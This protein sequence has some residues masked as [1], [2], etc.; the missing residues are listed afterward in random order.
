MMSADDEYSMKS[1]KIFLYNGQAQRLFW[2]ILDLAKTS[3]LSEIRVEW[4]LRFP[5]TLVMVATRQQTNTSLP[6]PATLGSLRGPHDISVLSGSLHFR[7]KHRIMQGVSPSQARLG[8]GQQGQR[9]KRSRDDSGNNNNGGQM[10]NNNAGQMQN[11]H[12]MNNMNQNMNPNMNNAALMQNRVLA[13]MQGPGIM[14]TNNSMANNRDNR[15]FRGNNM[16]MSSDFMSSDSRYEGDEDD[17]DEDQQTDIKAEELKYFR[18]DV[19]RS[20]ISGSA[21]SLNETISNLGLLG[22]GRSQR[23]RNPKDH[24]FTLLSHCRRWISSSKACQKKTI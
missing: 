17:F 8:G 5:K 6:Q 10:F 15:G 12:Q 18:L 11:M 7:G 14:G 4:K 21:S 22:S 2:R 20:I 3:G 9:G 23:N 24:R 19:S 16:N 13:S 1:W